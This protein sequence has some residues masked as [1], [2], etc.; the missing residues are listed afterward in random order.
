M[1][2]EPYVAKAPA[3]TKFTRP[4]LRALAFDHATAEAEAA[5]ASAACAD[6]RADALARARDRLA[7]AVFLPRRKKIQGF[8]SSNIRTNFHFI[9]ILQFPTWH[10]LQRES[11]RVL[12]AS[13]LAEL[14]SLPQSGWRLV[15]EVAMERAPTES[16]AVPFLEKHSFPS[17]TIET[18]RYS[19]WQEGLF[20][21]RRSF[22]TDSG[23]SRRRLPPHSRAPRFASRRESSQLQYVS[24]ISFIGLCISPKDQS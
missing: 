15:C 24:S 5:Q 17:H 22:R 19:L 14:K 3:R 13:F 9:F 18:G 12:V 10:G 4:K 23:A 7:P 16:R 6:E 2:E 11:T 8:F 21:G 1:C 20:V